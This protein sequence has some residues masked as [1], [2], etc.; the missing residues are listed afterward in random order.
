MILSDGLSIKTGFG[1][2]TPPG[3]NVFNTGSFTTKSHRHS[4][5]ETSVVQVSGGSLRTI[6]QEIRQEMSDKQRM[7]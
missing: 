1:W 6:V 5:H 3:A 4:P 2:L 7:Q